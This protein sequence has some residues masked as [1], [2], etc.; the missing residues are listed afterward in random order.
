VTGIVAPPAGP[1]ARATHIHGLGLGLNKN[2]RN[3]EGAV[4]FLQW[5][6]SEDAALAYATAGGSP[7]LTP[8]V[9]AKVAETRPDLV[10]L[11][12]FAGKY[13]YVMTGA[14]SA[15]ALSIYETQAK[16]FT[17]YWAGQQSLDEALAHTATSM[18]E[19]LK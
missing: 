12:D 19:M 6:A 18:G 10:M 5:L 14:T 13:G 17:G 1:E 2:A 11:G 16:E 3:K 9:V 15:D 7:A 4:R 8:E